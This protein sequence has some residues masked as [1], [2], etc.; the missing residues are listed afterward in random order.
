MPLRKISTACFVSSGMRS[1]RRKSP[2]VPTGTMA[3]F[4]D[5]G[6]GALLRKKPLTTSFSV[7]SPPTATTTGREASTL[8]WAIS[9]ASS[10]RV[11][12]TIS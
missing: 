11:V 9:V 1:V 4:V 2:P 3:S 8:R 5:V 12:F 10:G 7:P 6:M